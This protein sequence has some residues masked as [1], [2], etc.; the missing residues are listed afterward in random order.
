MITFEQFIKIVT[1]YIA[2]YPNEVDTLHVRFDLLEDKDKP[3]E[4]A[5]M[6]DNILMFPDKLSNEA[7]DSM[8][9]EFREL[10]KLKNIS[11]D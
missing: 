4:L 9:E 1:N 3:E 8:L 6:V 5:I 10:V 11:L 7:Y 2:L